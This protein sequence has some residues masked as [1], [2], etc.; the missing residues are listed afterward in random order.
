[1]WPKIQTSDFALIKPFPALPS[2]QQMVPER[3][4]AV[5]IPEQL[6]G[7]VFFDVGSVLIDLDWDSFYEALP[8]LASEVPGFEM[9][10]FLRRSRECDLQ[11][12]WCTG[13]LGPAAYAAH[14]R[15]CLGIKSGYAELPFPSLLDI[16]SASSLIVGA[17]RMR[18]LRLAKK[19]RAA[20]FGL[21]ILSNATPWHETDIE[22]TL[23]LRDNFDVV[24]FSQDYGCEKPEPE[25]YQRA[26]KDAQTYVR[27]RSGQS[28]T[29]SQVY[30]VDDTPDNVRAAAR[31]GW[32]AR[33]VCLLN[34]SLFEAA[35]LGRVPEDELARKSTDARNL[36]FGDEAAKRV[37]RLFA[38]LLSMST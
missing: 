24:V 23:S 8:Q 1:M 37:E 9:A 15:A 30:F 5:H 25:I 19:L 12:K 6:H 14:F 3:P 17:V 11:R 33:L 29:S 34:D 4:Y 20:N 26:L 36:V 28:L 13:E 16:K 22:T 2:R 27:N 38:E 10:N 7:F 32:N 35:N 31:Q 21:G 18:A